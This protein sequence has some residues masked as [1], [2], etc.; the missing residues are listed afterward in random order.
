MNGQKISVHYT[1]V[2]PVITERGTPFEGEA[3]ESAT[4]AVEREMRAP[5]VIAQ[6]VLALQPSTTDLT[7]E[8]LISSGA[9]GGGEFTGHVSTQ[10]G[11]I[12]SS[13]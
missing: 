1:T 12:K 5:N 4:E 7:V 6:G 9:G 8:H 10:S 11:G 3:A 2:H 13:V